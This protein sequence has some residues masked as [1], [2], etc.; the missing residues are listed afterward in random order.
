MSDIVERLQMPLTSTVFGEEGM[1]VI[2]QSE[3]EEAAAEIT[4]LRAEVAR[5]Q[6]ACNTFEE[7]LLKTVNKLLKLR[8]VL[9]DILHEATFVSPPEDDGSQWCHLGA[10]TM[11]DARAARAEPPA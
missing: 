3:R 4:R 5:L 9:R 11:I 2:V 8:V 7:V 10:Q 1:R 6:K